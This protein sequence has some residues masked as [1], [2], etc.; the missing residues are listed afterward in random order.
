MLID[1]AGHMKGRLAAFVAKTLLEGQRVKV[2]RC[3]QITLAGPFYR[4]KYIYQVR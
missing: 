3:E 4:Q 2:L 1:A